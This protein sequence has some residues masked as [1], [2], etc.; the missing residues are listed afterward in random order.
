MKILVEMGDAAAYHYRLGWVNAFLSLGHEVNY[1]NCRSKS[2][3]DVFFEFQPDIFI[4][5]TWNLS[6]PL[7]KCINNHPQLKV[8]LSAP[9]WGDFDSEID[10][11]D[12]VQF[13]SD[14]EKD[15][16]KQLKD[17]TGKPNYVMTYYHQNQIDKKKTHNHWETLGIKPVGIPMAADTTIYN[18]G[19][20]KSNLSSDIAFIGNYWK[21]KG[22]N[23]NQYILP[24]CHPTSQFK[25]KI[26]GTGWPVHTCLGEL[27]VGSLN[28]AKDIFRSAKICPA[29]Y[30][31]LSSKYGFDVSERIFKI[32]SSGGFCITEHIDSLAEDFDIHGVEFFNNIDEYENLLYYYTKPNN[33]AQRLSQIEMSTKWVYDN[34]TYHH[35][36]KKML[37]LLNEK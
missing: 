25:T 5:T 11:E 37:E 36:V 15:F 29:I 31:P 28:L 23:L 32:C 14:V 21:Y 17:L 20:E 16:V 24:Y 9:N 12:T 13:A 33:E 6:R 34:H 26:F 2:P 10:P 3:F 19:T 8:L 4:G 22:I 30:E 35:R 7:I 1:W 27:G 18:L